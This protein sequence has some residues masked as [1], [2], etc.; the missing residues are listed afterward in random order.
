MLVHP[1]AEIMS[2]PLAD[3]FGVVVVDVCC[4]GAC[5]CDEDEYQS[6][7]RCDVKTMRI[8]S[9]WPYKVTQ[10]R[11]KFVI[12]NDV[13]EDNFQ[14]PRRGETHNGLK[15]HGKEDQN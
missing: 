5:Y 14:R 3:A 4:H 7:Q 10:P 15:Q 11:G 2:N 12:A 6:C 9:K 8:F 1:H 13:V